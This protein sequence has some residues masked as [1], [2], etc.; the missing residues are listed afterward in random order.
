MKKI[1]ASTFTATIVLTLISVFN[2]GIAFFREVLYAKNFGLGDE[3]N[4]FL[5]SSV[6]PITIYSTIYYLSQFYFIP[7]YNKKISEDRN[8]EKKFLSDNL[9]IFFF[10]GSVV[11]ALLF[12]FSDTII[13]FYLSNVDTELKELSLKIFRVFIFTIPLSSAHS[14]L[15]AYLNAEQKFI[16]PA[17]SI[18]LLNLTVVISLYTLVEPFGIF[19]IP[20]GFVF[21]MLLQLIFLLTK[22]SKQIN[23]N[24]LP[25][26][27]NDSLLNVFN[28]TLLLTLLAEVITFSY[29]I[30]DRYFLDKLGEGGVAS[31]SYSYQIY[32]LPIK[33]FTFAIATI[34]FSKFSKS[35]YSLSGKEL[36]KQFQMG[37]KL[38]I[39]IFTP[40]ALI[41]FF[42][43]DSIIKILYE[44]G[45]FSAEDTILTFEILKIYTL[46]IVLYSAY[47]IVNKMIYSAG[48]LKYLLLLTSLGA[49]VK[50]IFSIIL[51][52]DYQQT[53]LAFTTS[54]AYGVICIS[55]FVIIVKKLKFSSYI[56][57]LVDFLIYTFIGTVC[58]LISNLVS[59]FLFKGGNDINYASPILFVVLYFIS[60]YYLNT[61]EVEWVKSNFKSNLF[62][63]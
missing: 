50:I 8:E 27:K 60:V 15:A 54:L 6:L 21:G 7:S 47:A 53:G 35:F 61:K 10:L 46:S 38:A 52:D 12:L 51:I 1:V 23:F 62:K 49:A 29:M 18:V 24:P 59:V 63:K 48:L 42:W 55:G 44:R 31:L 9:W 28:K 20:Y 3:F 14:I 19:V 45:K 40:I 39:F 26:F 30:V 41:Y 13:D 33:I 5:V 34:I 2:K 56:F 58:A 37:I 22:C 36:E 17:V 16:Y 57:P 4:A 25:A 43:G 11:T 32:E